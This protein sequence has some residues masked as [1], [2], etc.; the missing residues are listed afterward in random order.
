MTVSKLEVITVTSAADPRSL[1]NALREVP[2]DAQITDLHTEDL[3]AMSGGVV[4]KRAYLTFER[5]VES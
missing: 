2:V 3:R 4:E 1:I 5:S